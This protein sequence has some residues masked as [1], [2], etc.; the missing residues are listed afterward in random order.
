MFEFEYNLPPL[1]KL[2]KVSIKP[3]HVKDQ[4]EIM[5]VE[6]YNAIVR[7]S[8]MERLHRRGI[9][10]T[11]A[12][13]KMHDQMLAQAIVSKKQAEATLKDLLDFHEEEVKATAAVPKKPLEKPTPLTKE[14]VR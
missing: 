4:I 7:N 8:I 12:M 9:L 14:D 5:I 3:L 13:Q 11:G 6:T 1:E 2:E 10:G